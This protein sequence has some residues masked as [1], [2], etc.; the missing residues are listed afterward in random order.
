MKNINVFV[1][2]A[3]LLASTLSF[4]GQDRGGGDIACEGRIKVI[5]EDLI[6]WIGQGGY[7]NLDLKSRGT[8][9]QYADRMLYEINK[10]SIEC[11]GK[12]D[13]GFP[14]LVFGV[15]KTCAIDMQTN[16]NHITCDFSKV[17]DYTEEALY[18]QIHHEYATAAGFEKPNAGDS[19]YEIS[20]QLTNY[21]EQQLVLKLAVKQNSPNAPNLENIREAIKFELSRKEVSTYDCRVEGEGMILNPFNY[22]DELDKMTSVRKSYIGDGKYA[23]F[24]YVFS[25]VDENDIKYEERITTEDKIVLDSVQLTI[26]RKQKVNLGTVED[27][28]IKIDYVSTGKIQ[29][30]IKTENK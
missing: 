8:P 26:L 19:D 9:K 11:V 18:K 24:E 6:T 4:A 1:F 3:M 21:L 2:A 23:Y 17:A 12:G 10:T 15:A 22:I 30:S 5:K 29:C 28:K 13:P 25:Y 7:K 20:N 14:V 16:E 27:P